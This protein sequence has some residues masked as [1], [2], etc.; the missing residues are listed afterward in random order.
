MSEELPIYNPASEPGQAGAPHAEASPDGAT[1]DG[2][3][4]ASPGS[5]AAI[6]VT[7]PPDSFPGYELVKE[8]HRGGQGVIY[9]AV[10][11]STQRRVAIKVMK[12]GPFAGKADQARFE[13]EIHIL[14]QMNHPN[15]VTIHDSGQ[16]AGCHYFVMDYISGQPLDAWLT[17]RP[18][19][20]TEALKLFAKICEAVNAAHLRGV[21][22]RDLKPGNIRI[23]ENGQPYVL[24]FGLAKTAASPQEASV[25]TM[26]GQF[27]GSLPWASP[28]QA[29]AIPGKIDIRT[30]VYSLGVILFQMLTGKFPYDVIGN[31]R[32][33]LDRIISAMPPRPSMVGVAS[34]LRPGRIDDELDTIVLK[35][36]QK[37][38][39]RRYQSAGD[40]ARDIGHYLRGEPI[41]AKRDSLMYVARK[42]VYR[43]RT[44]IA[45]AVALG[46]LVIALVVGG[47]VLNERRAAEHAQAVAEQ[48]RAD[49][50]ALV[51]WV[52]HLP[53]VFTRSDGTHEHLLAL[54]A[55]CDRVRA[56][57]ATAGECEALVRACLTIGWD[58][59]SLV[60]PADVARIR[61]NVSI[62]G[63]TGS[64][65][66]GL[67][68]LVI[69]RL[70][71]DD[72]IPLDTPAS[73]SDALLWMAPSQFVSGSFVQRA[74]PG[75]HWV[76]GS[77]HVVIVRTLRDAYAA[78]PTANAREGTDYALI[79]GATAELPIPR[80]AFTVVPHY[81]E[82]YPPELVDDDMTADLDA[83]FLLEQVTLGMSDPNEW[84]AD[85]NTHLFVTAS[86]LTPK[87]SFPCDVSV[88]VAAA[89]W[90]VV[91]PVL[92]QPMSPSPRV[93]SSPDGALESCVAT[94]SHG[95]K[96]LRLFDTR[97]GDTKISRLKC[98]FRP[99]QEAIEALRG[100]S[101]VRFTV[102]TS[103]AVA[104]QEGVEVYLDCRIERSAPAEVA[105]DSENSARFNEAVEAL[106]HALQLALE[107]GVNPDGIGWLNDQAWQVVSR[108]GCPADL[109][110]L[111]LSLVEAVCRERPNDGAFLN[112]LG[113]AQYRCE[114]WEDAVTTLT[115]SNQINSSSQLG[116]QP[117]DVAFLAMVL[118]RLDKNE[119]ARNEFER[120]RELVRQEKWTAD[121]EA[122]GFLHEAEALIDR[123]SQ[124]P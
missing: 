83:S 16:A 110:D 103:D 94:V 49:V 34:R 19:S 46:V 113:V 71:L 105:S 109:Y 39:E 59:R 14:G 82:N 65:V 123:V 104:H 55:L 81:P 96:K 37:E 106:R 75:Q 20:I 117:A 52:A 48:Q 9:Q 32:D 6:F 10:Q 21:I 115:R 87:L 118:H 112:T 86:F 17:S 51:A 76:D 58:Q 4:L 66:R 64:W 80:F 84:S 72:H 107:Q 28:E 45:V 85:L 43:Y 100:G 23:D 68:L 42:L 124:D 53:T 57:S 50:Q 99:S 60:T 119:E 79:P 111:A 90:N 2:A 67:G 25:M 92:V 108:P 24:D 70:V 11:K 63:I 93:R 121:E 3:T 33:V 78:W 54:Q 102:T 98:C 1:Y 30:D 44:R 89:G 122:L 77:F 15:I 27:M 41:V 8:I 31:M 88:S 69:P 116:P 29:E 38:R 114:H 36:L 97:R 73:L 7:P 95:D 35:C 56:G 12:E 26:T 120:L 18:A 13:R 40:L 74:E 101:P 5:S 61:C 62:Q 91:L 22:H 47:M